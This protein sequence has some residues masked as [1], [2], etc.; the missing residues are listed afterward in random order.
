MLALISL[1]I[2]HL[3]L[4]IRNVKLGKNLAQKVLNQRKKTEKIIIDYAVKLLKTVEH[5]SVIERG[6]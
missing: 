3:I 5:C 1:K 4:I 2:F 6:T